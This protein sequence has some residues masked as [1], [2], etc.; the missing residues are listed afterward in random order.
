MSE[1]TE[2]IDGPR[3]CL[4]LA[5]WTL[6]KLIS[7]CRAQL[8]LIGNKQA[9]C[10][11]ANTFQTTTAVYHHCIAGGGSG[12]RRLMVCLFIE[13][14]LNLEKNGKKY[15]VNSYTSYI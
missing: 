7:T 9:P 4:E 15:T 10:S 2:Q 1:Y 3:K 5:T 12:G 13:K 14:D 11:Q 8:K 6:L